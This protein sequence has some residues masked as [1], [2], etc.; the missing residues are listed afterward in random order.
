MLFGGVDPL[1]IGDILVKE[2]GPEDFLIV[3]S[4]LSHYHN[5]K[6]AHNLDR[7]FIDAVLAG[8]LDAVAQAEA[9]GQA[10]ALALM[11]VALNQGWQPHLLNYRTSGDIMGDRSQVVGY[12]AIAYVENGD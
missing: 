2:L 4:D 3:S 10:P 8:Q 7:Q 5:N 1:E 12:A 6:T 11:K 9:C